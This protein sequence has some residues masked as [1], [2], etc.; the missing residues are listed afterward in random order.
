MALAEHPYYGSE[1]GRWCWVHT[2]EG[3]CRRPGVEHP[4]YVPPAEPQG[5]TTEEVRAEFVHGADYMEDPV[6]QFDAWLNKI[7]AATW[8][9]GYRARISGPDK[10]PYEEQ[11]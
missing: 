8:A 7:R 9:E 6:G 10:N 2:A 11:S 1:S 3:V 5:M 4:G